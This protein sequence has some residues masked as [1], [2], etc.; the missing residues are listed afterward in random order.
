MVSEYGA[1]F[2]SPYSIPECP[3]I[4]VGRTF[5]FDSMHSIPSHEGKCKHPHGHTYRLEVEVVG[6]RDSNG[7]VIDFGRLKEAMQPL[8]QEIDH[9]NLNDKFMGQTTAE[10]IV[11][12]L[13]PEVRGLVTVAGH[14][15]LHR[16]RLYEGDGKWAEVCSSS[17][18]VQAIL[19]P[20]SWESVVGPVEG[21]Q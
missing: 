12:A 3:V 13:W 17:S 18:A 16:L 19:G 8:L 21:S 10:N 2:M 1:S 4:W 7:F 20:S 15:A 5:V 14:V 11:Y 9:C 6:F